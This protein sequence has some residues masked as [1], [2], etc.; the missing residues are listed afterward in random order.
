MTRPLVVRFGAL[1]DMVLM[2]V[3]IRTLH[4]RFGEPVDVMGSGEWTRPLLEGQDGVGDIYLMGS[5]HRPYWLAADQWRL[6]RDL[7]RRGPGPTWLFDSSNERTRWLLRRAGWHDDNL[8]TLDRL[9]DIPGEHFCDHW[10][11]FA[12]LGWEQSRKGLQADNEML[13]YPELRVAAV[14]KAEV[15]EWLCQRDLVNRPIILIQ[16]G[17]K[18]TMRKGQFE[19][20]SNTKYWPESRWATLLQELQALHPEHAFLL[21][22]IAPEAALNDRILAMARLPHTC[23]LAR[24]M[25]VPR[26][27]GLAERADGMISVDTGPAHVAAAL[28]CPLVTM[29]DSTSKAVMYAPRGP[30]SA[31]QR[32]IVSGDGCPSLLGISVQQVLAAWRETRQQSDQADKGATTPAG[33]CSAATAR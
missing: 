26:L 18:R 33:V 5:R 9:P 31:C 32:I 15:S 19:R 28:G 11:R 27:M 7:R 6:I 1:G 23:N 17:N 2:T 12:M 20:P 25:S 3:A 10:R 22:G 8:L 13:A 4:E 14:T 29:F 16:V 30:Q 24:E 21:L